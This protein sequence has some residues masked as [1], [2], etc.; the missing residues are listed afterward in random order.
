MYYGVGATPPP[1][2]GGEHSQMGQEGKGDEERLAAVSLTF[3]P[4][5]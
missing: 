1:P 2:S 4:K 5:F 3:S